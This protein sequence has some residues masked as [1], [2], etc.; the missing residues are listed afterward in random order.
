MRILVTGGA[1]FIGSHIVDELVKLNHQVSIVDNLSTGSEENLNKNARFYKCDITNKE[2]LRLVFELEKPEIVIHHAAQ[3]DVQ[4]SLK[5]AAFDAKVNIRGTINVLEC[6]KEVK[7]RKIIYPSSA[8][9]Y[10]DPKYLPVDEEHPI[11]PISFYGISKHTPEHYIK[12]YSEL[13][14]IKYTIFRYSNVYGERQGAKGEGGV[15]SIFIDKFLAKEVPSIFGDG[16]QTRDFIYVKDVAKANLLA[17]DKGDNEIL[18][19]STNT[20]VSVNKLFEIMREIFVVKIVPVYKEVR[21]GDIEHSYLDN[22][23][24]KEIINLKNEY[25]LQEGLEETVKYYMNLNSVADEVAVAK[26]I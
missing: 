8:A 20:Q 26:N 18:N 1:G 4:T 9:V 5:K 11:N 14:G 6:C 24:A 13:Y 2:T 7:T 19:I 23:R 21:D 22:T 3:I 25:E 15:V 16:E 10:G 12:V 17:L